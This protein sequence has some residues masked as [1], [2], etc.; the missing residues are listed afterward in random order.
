MQRSVTIR[1]PYNPSPVK[2]NRENLGN[3]TIACPRH[4]PTK[5]DYRVP[6]PILMIPARSSLHRVFIPVAIVKEFFFC[7]RSWRIEKVGI[8]ISDQFLERRKTAAAIIPSMFPAGST[9]N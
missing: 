9:R 6:V 5:P 8:G 1:T 4:D 3:L 7:W 2:L